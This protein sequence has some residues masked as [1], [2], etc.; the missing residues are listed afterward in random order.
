M[1]KKVVET[2]AEIAKKALFV[3]FKMLVKC[4]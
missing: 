2:F 3:H 1:P 4:V